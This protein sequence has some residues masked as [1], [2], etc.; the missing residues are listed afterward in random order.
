VGNEAQAAVREAVL[1]ALAVAAPECKVATLAPARP[2]REQ[3]DLDSLDWLNLVDGLAERLGV[4]AGDPG[5]LAT[6]DALVAW[7]AAAQPGM[8]APVAAG[9]RDGGAKAGHRLADGRMV[10]LRPLC[11]GDA[12]LEAWFVAQLSAESRYQRFMTAV[13][14]LPER[15]LKDLTDA[16]GVRHVALVATTREAGR[17]MP[18]GIAH[19]VVDAGGSACEFAIVVSDA[20]RGSGLAGLLMDA[21]IGIARARGL[22]RMEG[23]VLASNRDMLRFARQLGFRRL[24]QGDGDGGVVRVAR[25][26]QQPAAGACAAA[27]PDAA[28]SAP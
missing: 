17:E 7:L 22:T 13:R 12:A 11:A 2:L 23:D 16:D 9:P 15:K 25:E 20:C 6:L 27:R 18:L 8:P 3:V 1:A 26:L 28:Q 14:E 4:R 24:P 19:Y 5:P 10:E 21:L